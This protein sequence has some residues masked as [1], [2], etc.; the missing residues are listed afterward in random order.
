MVHSQ[1]W[2]TLS[3][4]V[5]SVRWCSIAMEMQ[6]LCANITSFY[7]VMPPKLHTTNQQVCTAGGYY[8]WDCCSFY[9]TVEA[10]AVM[11]P[12]LLSLGEKNKPKMIKAYIF[13]L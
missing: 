7:N 4:E 1:D 11:W 10:T 5:E 12:A 9:I 2:S 3:I 8:W 6:K 13:L